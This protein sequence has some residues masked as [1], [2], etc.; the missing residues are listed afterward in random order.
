MKTIPLDKLMIET[1]TFLVVYTIPHSLFFISQ[2]RYTL[3]C[4]LVRNKAFAR[5]FRLRGNKVAIQ[6]ER[7]VARRTYDKRAVRTMPYYVGTM[8]S[9]ML[10]S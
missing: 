4:S 6:E 1:G 3:R 2:V 7:K 9:S 10:F 8:D 5:G